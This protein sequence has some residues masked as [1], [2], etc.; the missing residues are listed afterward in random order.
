VGHIINL[1]VKAL[2]FSEGVSK[3]EWEL[4]GAGDKDQ[5]RLWVKK[6]PIGRLHNI[7][8]YINQSDQCRQEFFGHQAEVAE[9][10]EIFYYQLLVDGG[11]HWNAVY[12]MIKRALKLQNAIDL[13]LLRWQRP[14]NNK[15]AYDLHKDV[16]SDGDWIELERYFHLL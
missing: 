14:Y 8:T 4:C 16:L 9:D 2:L 10:N 3:F 12:Y 7:V 11:V 15:D 6:G 5:F 1:I 13:Y